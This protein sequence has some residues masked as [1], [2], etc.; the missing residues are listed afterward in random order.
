MTLLLEDH[1]LD[2]MSTIE[3]GYSCPAD[4]PWLS[5]GAC[6]PCP[7]MRTKCIVYSAAGKKKAREWEE[8]RRKTLA[9]K[10]L[11]T[12]Q[13]RSFEKNDKLPAEG[14]QPLKPPDFSPKT[15]AATYVSSAESSAPCWQREERRGRDVIILAV[16]GSNSDYTFAAQAKLGSLVRAVYPHQVKK[17]YPTLYAARDAAILQLHEW[18]KTAPRAKARLKA[19]DL[20]LCGQRE[21][22]PELPAR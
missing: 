9:E 2:Y 14:F 15:T 1:S 7:Y 20:S 8:K 22:F 10:P 16:F 21:L 12:T 17:Q 5:C 4:R 13:A 11:E 3:K 19:F 6:Q 18:T